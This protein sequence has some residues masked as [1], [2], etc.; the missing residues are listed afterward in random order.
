MTYHDVEFGYAFPSAVRLRLGV[1]NVT[2]KDPPFID[3]NVGPNT[4]AATYR[5]LGRTFFADVRWQMR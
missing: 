1:G 2:D 3:N 5:L 4:D